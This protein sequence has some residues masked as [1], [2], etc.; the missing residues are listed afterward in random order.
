[1]I[2]KLLIFKRKKAKELVVYQHQLKFTSSRY[3]FHLLHPSF[4]SLLHLVSHRKVILHQ[5]PIQKHLHSPS[6]Q[7]KNLKNSHYMKK[8]AIA[9]AIQCAHPLSLPEPL[10]SVYPDFKNGTNIKNASSSVFLHLPSSPALFIA[11]SFI[12]FSIPLS[13]VIC[14]FLCVFRLVE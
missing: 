2:K 7:H 12:W 4:S 8:K 5:L 9:T 13:D 1:M 6:E 10:N 3:T 14:F 11:E